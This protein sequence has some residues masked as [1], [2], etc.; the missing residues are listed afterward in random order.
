MKLRKLLGSH[1]SKK[2]GFRIVNRYGIMIFQL[3]FNRKGFQI[4]VTR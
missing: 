4:Q 2:K 3:E 1:I